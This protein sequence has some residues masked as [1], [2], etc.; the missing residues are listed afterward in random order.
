MPKVTG[1]CAHEVEHPG[2]GINFS[3]VVGFTLNG[4]GRI[5]LPDSN[6][7]TIGSTTSV[8]AD[9]T[10]TVDP[11]IHQDPTSQRRFQ[12]L[13]DLIAIF[14]QPTFCP[15]GLLV[16]RQPGA[17]VEIGVVRNSG[18]TPLHLH[19]LHVGLSESPPKRVVGNQVVFV[20]D[21]LT[22]P[23]NSMYFL[24]VNFPTNGTPDSAPKTDSFDFHWDLLTPKGVAHCAETPGD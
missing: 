17:Y 13:A 4:G 19:G 2:P 11:V 12:Y 20:T 23:A 8:P 15:S 3:G 16:A 24:E 6:W 10:V 5:K 18:H 9:V 14:P 22:L 21:S 1:R 7:Y